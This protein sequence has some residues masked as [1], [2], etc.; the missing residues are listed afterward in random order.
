ML[1]VPRERNVSFTWFDFTRFKSLKLSLEG[2]IV[3]AWKRSKILKSREW[4]K[5]IKEAK[6]CTKA[7]RN[8]GAWRDGGTL[9]TAG[10]HWGAGQVPE[11]EMG[12]QSR[13]GLGRKDYGFSVLPLSC[14]CPFKRQVL[15]LYWNLSGYLSPLLF[16]SAS[17]HWVPATWQ[18]LFKALGNLLW[19]EHSTCL[20]GVCILLGQTD[21]KQMNSL[22]N[23]NVGN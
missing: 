12:R 20:R 4:R 15:E 9:Q 1:W 6:A 13:E 8:K 22:K 5:N 2:W 17:K 23:V 3:L 19:A 10:S 16:Y 14:S 18:A 21:G 7:R 11:R